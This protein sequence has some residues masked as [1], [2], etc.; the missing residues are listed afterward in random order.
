MTPPALWTR[1][2]TPRSAGH[3][4][5]IIKEDYSRY[6]D[7]INGC[8]V[9]YNSRANTF[10]IYQEEM[11]SVRV[12]PCSTFKVISTLIGLEEGLVDSEESRMGYDGTIYENTT[13]NQDLNLKEAFQKSCV[14]YYRG[15]IS[16]PYSAVVFSISWS[17]SHTSGSTK[18]QLVFFFF[19]A[20]AKASRRMT[21]A[22]LRHMFFKVSFIKFLTASL[23]RSRS[24]CSSQNVHH[25]FS[26]VP[27]LNSASMYGALGF[28][29]Y[30]L[31]ICSCVGSPLS[32]N[33]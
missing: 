19:T 15:R 25:I 16:A 1:K 12:S 33:S 30:I 4:A 6:F 2:P 20:Y 31:S 3:S 11:A 17:S 27:S 28:L 5:V 8:A 9:F 14:W 26:L 7:G 23:V 13:W 10:H 18:K 32:Q 24:T 21:A 22:P 29:L